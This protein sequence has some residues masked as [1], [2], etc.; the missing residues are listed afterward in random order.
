[1]VISP[2]L[3]QPPM[4]EISVDNEARA[5]AT[6]YVRALH[7]MLRMHRF[8]ATLLEF[9]TDDGGNMRARWFFLCD[10]G[11][12]VEFDLEGNIAIEYVSTSP[13]LGSNKF[14]IVRSWRHGRLDEYTW[15]K[16]V[17]MIHDEAPFNRNGT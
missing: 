15:P 16:L 14:N 7:A 4:G 13:M 10:N 11:R 6:G 5:R 8:P 12:R 17:A 3:F 2:N 9:E 1:M